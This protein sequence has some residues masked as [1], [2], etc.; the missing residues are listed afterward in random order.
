ML[1]GV[2]CNTDISAYFAMSLFDALHGNGHYFYADVRW[3]IGYITDDGRNQVALE[4]I[5]RKYDFLVFLDS[6]MVFKQGV[7][8]SMLNRTMDTGLASA[9]IY[10]TRSDH[11][12]NLYNWVPGKDAFTTFVPDLDYGGE[13][14]CAGTG[15]MCLPVS[16]F[17][18]IEFPF[19]HYD[20]KKDKTRW[21]E[22]MVFCKKMYDMGRRF[23]YLPIICSHI[24]DYM[25]KQVDPYN[26]GIFKLTGEQ[27]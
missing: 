24:V 12:V 20:Y 16:Y 4:A 10:N 17:D 23:S 14:D 11:R 25:V 9:C 6:D 15:A 2:V 3:A 21:S 8:L 13:C 26:Y 5:R 7:I 18:D 22:D 19:F 1:V 27:L